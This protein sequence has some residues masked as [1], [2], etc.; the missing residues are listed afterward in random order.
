MP[1]RYCVDRYDSLLNL[2]PRYNRAVKHHVSYEWFLTPNWM[3]RF[4]PFKLIKAN[5]LD[6][7]GLHFYTLSSAM[8]GVMGGV[9]GLA[10]VVLTDKLNASDLQMGIYTMLSVVAMLFGIV[11]AE[12]VEGRDKRP[13]ILW[14]GLISR[15][16]FLLFLFCYSSWVFIAIS[17]LFFMFHALVMPPMFAMWQ[18]N[19]SKEA[20]SKLWGMTVIITTLITM[21]SAYIAGKVLDWNPDSFRWMFAAAGVIAMVGIV[22]LA[23]SPLRGMHHLTRPPE[24]PS[25]QRWVVKPIKSFLGLMAEDRRYFHFEMVFFLYGLAVMLLFPIMPMYIVDV[26][27]MSYEQAGIATVIIGQLA[28]LV[29]PP[30]WGWVMDRTGPFFLCI[31]IFAILALFPGILLI[32]M[33][34]QDTP[35]LVVAGVY[36]AY[37]VFG[38]GMSGVNVAWSMGPVMFAGKRDS[39]GYS[40]AHITITGIRGLVGPMLGA[41]GKMY[42]GF[43]PVLATSA[44]LFLIGSI[45]MYLL[46]RHY[47]PPSTWPENQP[48]LESTVTGA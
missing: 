36:I 35:A 27:H 31:V 24:S 9:F 21:I 25:F 4:G 13:Y 1:L 12:V 34:F 43:G 19:I 47:G 6:R 7:V 42:L 41:L 11:S 40:G 20:R 5:L 23:L 29:L 2:H 22:V 17:A 14:L 33:R 16:A 37:L 38:V 8:G 39:S 18:A 28:T 45:G 15:G 32:G 3:R 48:V 26:A 30:V 46:R 44:A 10:G